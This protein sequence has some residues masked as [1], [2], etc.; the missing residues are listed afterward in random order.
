VQE[1]AGIVGIPANTV[2]TRVFYARRRLSEL[3]EAEGIVGA[4]S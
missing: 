4:L 2:K 3:L 1:V